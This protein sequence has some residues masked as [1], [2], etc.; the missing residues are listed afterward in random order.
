MKRVNVESGINIIITKKGT[1]PRKC[2]EVVRARTLQG[3]SEAINLFKHLYRGYKGV[4]IYET[5]VGFRVECKNY[6]EALPEAVDLRNELDEVLWGWEY[7][8]Q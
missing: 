3:F 4:Y 7:A 8:N 5:R 6:R 1:V 2:F